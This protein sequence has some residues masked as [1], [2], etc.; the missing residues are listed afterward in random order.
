MAWDLGDGSPIVTDTLQTNHTYTSTGTYTA[1]L[2]VTDNDG[3]SSSNSLTITV[4][5]NPPVIT[6]LTGDTEIN[7]GETTNFSAEASDPNNDEL[8]YIWDFGNDSDLATGREVNHI[9][10]DNGNYTVT[11]TVTDTEGSATAQTLDVVVN[12][13]TPTI[14]ELTG[15]TNINEGEE[16]SYSAIANDPG[17]DTLTYTWNFGDG[18]K[19]VEGQNVT[20][21]FA[22]NGNYTITLTVTD[23]DNASTN[24]TLDVT[25]KQCNSYH[26]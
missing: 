20:H 23:D 8:T 13:V 21:T 22:D 25:V 7:E 5:N 14:T 4:N 9:F 16:A 15:D 6:E 11:L 12:N 1:T 17:N 19:Q 2:T 24:Q 18:S 3:A 26:Y 10:R